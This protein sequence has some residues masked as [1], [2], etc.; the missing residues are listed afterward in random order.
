MYVCSKFLRLILISF[1]YWKV[2][3]SEVIWNNDIVVQGGLFRTDCFFLIFRCYLSS[4]KKCFELLFMQMV[5][6]FVNRE[7]I[8]NRQK[9]AITLFLQR[10]KVD[11]C[12]HFNR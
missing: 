5:M 7:V 6:S 3:R 9:C 1:L 11:T 8:V 10:L 4:L 12:V 2:L